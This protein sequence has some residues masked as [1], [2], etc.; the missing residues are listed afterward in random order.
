MNT[1][2]FKKVRLMAILRNLDEREITDKE[3][4]VV[5]DRVEQLLDEYRNCSFVI[6][7]TDNPNRREN[8]YALMDYPI[9]KVVF[10]HPSLD[11]IDKM[12]KCVIRYFKITEATEDDIVNVKDGG[13]GRRTRSAMHY[14][15]ITIKK[16]QQ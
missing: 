1:P 2:N 9:F 3:A 15:Y 13:A 16:K 5:I 7:K 4:L 10:S 11:V 8:E 6:G 14:I 12:E